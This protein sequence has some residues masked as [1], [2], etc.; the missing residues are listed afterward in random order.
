MP[1]GGKRAGGCARLAAGLAA[2][3]APGLAGCGFQPLYAGKPGSGV[4][5]DIAAVRIA[6]IRDRS[7]QILRNALIERLNPRGAPADPRHVLETSLAVTRQKLGIRKDE[8]ATRESLRFTAVFRL[9]ESASGAIVHSGR[10][11][12]IASYNIVESEYA[13]IAS[14]RAARRR[15]LT[16]VA[17]RMTARLS[18]W[19]N[20]LRSLRR[21]P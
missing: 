21:R 3:L 16:L 18:A 2:L 7:G 1:A 11:A 13:T 15:G 12:A 14:E 17:E 5:D 6:P 20:R 4:A 19:F 9:R 8:T 10:A